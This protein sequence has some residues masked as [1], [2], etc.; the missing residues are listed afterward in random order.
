MIN[1]KEEKQLLASLKALETISVNGDPQV[2]LQR[3]LQILTTY[4]KNDNFWDLV[5]FYDRSMERYVWW[6]G[7]RTDIELAKKNYV[8]EHRAKQ[9][10]KKKVVIPPKPSFLAR[11]FGKKS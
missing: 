3:V 1:Q 2:P 4:R 5:T 9:E 10:A 11:V 6:V 8:D 7:P